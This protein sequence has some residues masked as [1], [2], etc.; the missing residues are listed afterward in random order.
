MAKK[1]TNRAYTYSQSNALTYKL[2]QTSYAFARD[3]AVIKLHNSA[4]TM[5]RHTCLYGPGPNAL[6]P[7]GPIV[8]GMSAACHEVG[9]SA[10]PFS[11]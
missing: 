10:R 4:S 5:A 7:A 8:C 6:L 11:P 3:Y 9:S 2:Q 1:I